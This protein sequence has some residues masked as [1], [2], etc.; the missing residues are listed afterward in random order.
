MKARHLLLIS[1]LSIGAAVVLNSEASAC[2]RCGGPG[3]ES[4][5][6]GYCSNQRWGWYGARKSV[7]SAEEARRD[8]EEFYSESDVKIGKVS[9]RSAYFEAEVLDRN[10]RLKDRVIIHK[11]SGRIRS[12]R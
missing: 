4:S 8:L 3:W 9:E 2:S 11:R 10:N 1:L 12:I 6:N 7:N 5:Y